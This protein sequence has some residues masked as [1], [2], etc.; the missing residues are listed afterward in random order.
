MSVDTLGKILIDLPGEKDGWYQQAS[1]STAARPSIAKLKYE[2]LSFERSMKH[3]SGNDIQGYS[4]QLTGNMIEPPVYVENYQQESYQQ[5]QQQQHHQHDL[6]V[7]TQSVLTQMG[8]KPCSPPMQFEAQPTYKIAPTPLLDEPQSEES[9]PSIQEAEDVEKRSEKRREQKMKRQQLVN[10]NSPT[11]EEQCESATFK[12]PR[13]KK[14]PSRDW[15]PS[16]LP[17]FRTPTADR[18]S[19][20]RGKFNFRNNREKSKSS[21]R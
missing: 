2:L 3:S 20:Y 1:A 18:T 14:S 16:D 5:P 13:P 12:T 8:L 9:N 17:G 6:G 21:R 15:T 10:K 4:L 7:Q 19:Y 11:A